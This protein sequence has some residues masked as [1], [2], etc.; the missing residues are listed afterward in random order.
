MVA[1][2]AAGMRRIK[3][4]SQDQTQDFQDLKVFRVDVLGEA[5]A[6]A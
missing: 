2:G 4:G 6:Q 5:N 1:F 3:T